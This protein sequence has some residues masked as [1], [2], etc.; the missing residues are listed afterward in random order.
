MIAH[1]TGIDNK[2]KYACSMKNKTKMTII[3]I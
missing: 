3:I 1:L 2:K